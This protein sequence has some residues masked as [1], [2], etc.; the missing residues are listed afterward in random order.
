MPRFGNLLR[1]HVQ[2][3]REHDNEYEVPTFNC[4]WAISI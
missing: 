4:I 1:G 2:T 3:V